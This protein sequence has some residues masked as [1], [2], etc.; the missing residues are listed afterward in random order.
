MKIIP[1]I[2]PDDSQGEPPPTLF[3]YLPADSLLFIDESHVTVPQLGGMYRGDRSRKETLV[4]YGFRLPSALDNRPL[5][6]E[7]FLHL[8]PPT[9]FV[10]A[11]PANYERE[12]SA[13]IVEQLVRPTGLIDPQVIVR[14]ATTQVDDLCGE[15]TERVKKKERV[16]TTTLTKRM[17]EKLTEFLTESGIRARYL[18]A[19]IDTVERVEILRDLRLGVFDVSVLIFCVRGWICRKFRWWRF[20]TPTRRVFCVPS[21]L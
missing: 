15:I 3:D 19:D 1:A 20:L 6:F 12:K 16:L 10:S 2:C 8:S 21:N 18:H 14:P 5:Q 11:T 7:E 13:Q 17:A 4:E 9:I